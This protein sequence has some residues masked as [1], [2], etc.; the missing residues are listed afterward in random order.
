MPPGD[1]SYVAPDETSSLSL[2]P[3]SA[4]EREWVDESLPV[5]Q[6]LAQVEADF[7]DDF[8]FRFAEA[9]VEVLGFEGA[10]PSGARELLDSVDLQYRVIENVGFDQA[11]YLAEVDR[12][13]EYYA[14]D[15]SEHLQFWVSPQPES[16]PGSIRVTAASDRAVAR[17]AATAIEA[18]PVDEPFS[19]EFD[20]QSEV[21]QLN[22]WGR[23][24][25]T[26]LVDVPSG[27]GACTSAFVT[28]ST[29]S[30]DLGVLTA[31]HCPTNLKY[32]L[33][34]TGEAYVMNYRNHTFGSGGDVMFLRSSLMMDPWFHVSNTAGR[35]VNSVVNPDKGDTVC[36]YGRATGSASCGK[37]SDKNVT[38]TT[39]RGTVGRQGIIT[40]VTGRPGDSGGPVYYAN[41]AY[42][43]HSSSTTTLVAFTLIS[44][45]QSA[46]GTSVC[47][48]PGC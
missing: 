31:G 7:S 6:V 12:I 16:T 25:G 34:H 30:T 37:L 36:Q 26:W 9:G 35:P 27:Q 21:F 44:Y 33:P 3:L 48:A 40:G 46:T 19:V 39:D 1:S 2:D 42:G 5:K 8:A 11:D 22:S 29:S 18:P 17:S 24:G 4:E 41:T 38:I 15:A 20:S 10:A 28:K 32:Y 13:A 14:D 43:V 45:A 23:A 47:R